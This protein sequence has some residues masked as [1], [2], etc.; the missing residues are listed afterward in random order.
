MGVLY[1]FR[2]ERFC[3]L[4]AQMV[5]P[6]DARRQAGYAKGGRWSLKK[7]MGEKRIQD[8]IEA[9]RE[10]GAK[11]SILSRL[12]ILDGV[13]QEWRLSRAAGQHGAAL[14][15]A[16]MYGGETHQMFRSKVEVGKVG[17][18][19]QKSEEELRAYIENQMKELGISPPKLIEVQANPESS[20]AEPDSISDAN[21]VMAER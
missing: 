14:R 20:T 2:E 9:L 11:R 10:Q 8:R 13:L 3:Q 18:F 6:K 15:A 12:D 19:D 16:E 17:D 21:S 1:D 4:I 7:L 5:V